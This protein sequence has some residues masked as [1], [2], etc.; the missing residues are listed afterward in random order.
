MFG[1]LAF[2]CVSQLDRLFFC[3]FF[4]FPTW[5]PSFGKIWCSGVLTGKYLRDSPYAKKVRWWFLEDF[6]RA[7]ASE[8]F[9]RKVKAK[10]KWLCWWKWCF[11]NKSLIQFEI[12][13]LVRMVF[14]PSKHT[15]SI[16][17]LGDTLRTAFSHVAA[18]IKHVGFIPPIKYRYGY[19]SI[20]IYIYIYKLFLGDEDPFTNYF[21][22]T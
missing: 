13:C 3:V 11:F 5:I 20:H 17:V 8:F 16:L 1:K 10:L 4:C 18:G 19:G 12:V 21:D 9:G 14:R 22:V 7:G 15:C 2:P 6:L